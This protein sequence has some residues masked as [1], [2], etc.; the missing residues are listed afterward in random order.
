MYETNSYHTSLLNDEKD[1]EVEVQP[2]DLSFL[3]EVRVSLNDNLAWS[4]C[5]L[6]N[7]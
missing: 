4:N 7:Y 2:A 5:S 1:E 3:F 6:E